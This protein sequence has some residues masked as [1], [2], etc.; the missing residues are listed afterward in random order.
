MDARSRSPIP[1]AVIVSSR[2][3]DVEDGGVRDSRSP[4]RRRPG[5][6]DGHVALGQ[7]RRAGCHVV[8]L[9]E[10]G[11]LELGVTLDAVDTR[12]PTRSTCSC[13]HIA[14]ATNASSCCGLAERWQ[15]TTAQPFWFHDI[16]G[17]VVDQSTRN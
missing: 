15:R 13:T 6:T 1:K 16:S 8:P 11:R 12:A 3:L 2:T 9:N 14:C 17:A 10:N 5:S 4:N 7:W